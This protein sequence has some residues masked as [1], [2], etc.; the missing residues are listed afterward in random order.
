MAEKEFEH[1][2]PFEFVRMVLDIP[3]DDV[4]YAQ[5]T[6]TF[7]EEYMLM[8]WSDEE[9]LALFQDP[10]Y[11]GTHDILVKKGETFVKNTI[12]EVRHG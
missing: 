9:I 2:D 3:A 12:S 5:M 1:E 4:F 6:R 8:G 7:V 10:F 11:Q